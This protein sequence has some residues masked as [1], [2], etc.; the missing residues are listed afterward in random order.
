M[1]PD[2]RRGGGWG[3]GGGGG[4][5]GRR[6]GAPAG[7]VTAAAPGCRLV[8][9]WGEGSTCSLKKRWTVRVLHSGARRHCPQTAFGSSAGARG[10]VGVTRVAGR[11]GADGAAVA[12]AGRV[13]G[14]FGGVK[15]RAAPAP[16]RKRGP[17]AG[18]EEP[19]AGAQAPRLVSSRETA[20]RSWGGSSRS[21]QPAV[22]VRRARPQVFPVPT[23]LSESAA[24]RLGFGPQP[25]G[26][27][28]GAG[29]PVPAQRRVPAWRVWTQPGHQPGGVKTLRML[30]R[31]RRAWGPRV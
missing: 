2:A 4:G 15:D 25:P 8:C 28:S 19:G 12:A 7:S 17:G 24:L 11:R 18:G 1:G 16:R 5:W 29:R 9:V 3:M 14:A 10:A 26:G 6:P 13:R 20:T 31:W 30:L 23:R 21:E 27:L 22:Q